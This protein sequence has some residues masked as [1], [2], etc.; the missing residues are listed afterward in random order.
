MGLGF[1][2]PMFVA[3]F[4]ITLGFP[5]FGIDRLQPVLWQAFALPLVVGAVD[6]R[7]RGCRG[8]PC[9]GRGGDALGAATGRGGAGR[10]HRVLV[11]DAPGVHRVPGAGRRL[12]RTAARLREVRRP[13]RRQRRR[14]GDPARG[15]AAEPVGDDPRGLDGRDGRAVGRGGSR[16]PARP[17]R[18]PYRERRGLVPRRLRGGER[19]QRHVPVVVRALRARPGVA[20]VLG[21]RAAGSGE[22]TD[23]A[24]VSF[25][26]R[27]AASCSRCCAAW[28]RGARPSWCRPGRAR[29]AVRSRSARTRSRPAASR[30]PG[31]SSGVCSGAAV[32]W[33][34]RVAA[35]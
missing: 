23:A 12:R 5:Q 25:E 16:G 34:A 28:P 17:L 3:A 19:N 9:A 33:P 13:D 1:A 21:G 35:G 15:P 7:G 27:S 24:S 26:A 32:P 14:D 29:S 20:C 31:G 11:G 2:L 4:P 18:H 10:R 30:S 6:G 22:K 8:S